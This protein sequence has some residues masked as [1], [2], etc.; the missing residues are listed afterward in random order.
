MNIKE[1]NNYL[2][3][4]LDN[5]SYKTSPSYIQA[6]IL[7]KDNY[8][9]EFLSSIKISSKKVKIIS[10]KDSLSDIFN[11]WLENDYS[12]TE[13]V[14]SSIINKLGEPIKIMSVDKKT[15]DNL[16]CRKY[17]YCYFYEDMYFVEFK[18]ITICFILGNN[19]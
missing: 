9:E 16:S 10:T 15:L 8:K 2:K 19:E 11:N 18:K 17:G 4:L 14:I 5:V 7:D 13:T 12:L 1:L 6:V 3:D